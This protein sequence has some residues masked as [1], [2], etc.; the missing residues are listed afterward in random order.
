M[1]TL[2]E[3]LRAR[4]LNDS[5]DIESLEKQAGIVL[6]PIYKFFV[7]S[8]Y[9]GEKQIYREQ[10]YNE[11]YK[12]YFD[13]SSYI[14]TSNEDVGFSHIIEIENSFNVWNS[15]GLGD[16][17]YEKKLFPIISGN[18][19]SY[20]GLE[21]D[22]EDKIIMLKPGFKNSEIILSDNIFEFVR[23]IEILELKEDFMMDIK[24]SQ[25]YKNWGEDFWR[26]REG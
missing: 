19:S 12:D 8:F 24:Y 9:L 10:Y 16:I 20:V 22:F 21:K 7:Q 25:L 17:C 18:F 4:P 5:V 15:N 3:L 2:F 6:P 26:V 23:G 13:C 11:F 14:Y 1:R